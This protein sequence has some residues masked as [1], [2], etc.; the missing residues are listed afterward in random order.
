MKW[1]IKWTV[2]TYSLYSYGL[3]AREIILIDNLADPVHG[4]TLISILNRKYQLPQK[5]ITYNLHKD[6]C[7]KGSDA[8][9][10]LCIK[11][12]GDID[13]LKY[14][15][16]VLEKMLSVFLESEGQDEI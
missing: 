4:K 8:I 1:I 7:T 13:V 11:R 15:Q 2:F 14:E 16:K 6:Q 10:H 3:Y 12:N 9:L 5:L